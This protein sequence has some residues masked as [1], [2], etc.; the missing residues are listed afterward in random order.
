MNSDWNTEVIS[1]S[2]DGFFLFGETAFDVF[3]T[4]CRDIA[5]V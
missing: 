4:V 5:C 3:V 2:F 1:M